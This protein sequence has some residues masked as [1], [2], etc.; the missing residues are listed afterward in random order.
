MIKIN[1]KIFSIFLIFVFT[2]LFLLQVIKVWDFTIDDTYITLRYAKHWAQGFGILWNINEAPVEGYS[3]FLFVIL[4]RYVLGASF[5]PVP[6]LKVFGV[7]GSLITAISIFYISRFFSRWY[8]AIVPAI[9]LLFYKGQVIWSVSGLE[10]SIFQALICL[11]VFCYLNGLYYNKNSIDKDYKTSYLI[12]SGVLFGIASLTRPEGPLFILLFLLVAFISESRSGL[13][14]IVPPFLLSFLIIFL[15]YFLWRLIYFKTL[16]ANPVYCKGLSAANYLQLDK[17]FLGIFW[18]FFLLTFF[19]KKDKFF[20]YLFLPSVMY[21]ILL[22]SADPIVAFDNR[23]FFPALALLLPLSFRTLNDFISQR[24]HNESVCYALTIFVSLVIAFFLI[25]SF[26]LKQYETFAKN[27]KAGEQLREKVVNWL[28]EFSPE[29]SH[30]VLGDCG[31]IPYKT[32]HNYIDSYCLNNKKMASVKLE[33]RYDKFCHDI[34]KNLPE[35]IILTSLNKNNT[36]VR[37]PCDAILHQELEKYRQY[38]L[39]V[40]FSI[41]NK[42]SSYK[43]EIFALS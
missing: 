39:K 21:L 29:N 37:S 17:E 12:I 38:N 28:N 13:I 34:I 3:N 1:I 27:P 8:L 22:V 9:W 16:F 43:Y 35:F 42:D 6:F 18:P 14:K 23:L 2:S 15:P 32:K 10:T 33:D 20:Y 11:A 30:I 7:L 40:T 5:D 41:E 24:I 4:A 19:A 31:L 26:T 25:P 36:V